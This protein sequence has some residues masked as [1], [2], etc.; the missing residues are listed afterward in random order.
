M[1]NKKRPDCGDAQVPAHD[2]T[3][4]LQT[5]ATQLL[6]IIGTPAAYSIHDDGG[7]IQTDAVDRLAMASIIRDLASSYAAT[8]KKRIAGTMQV[9]DT[10]TSQLGA[11]LN[12]SERKGRKILAVSE[13]R[14]QYD[15]GEGEVYDLITRYGYVHTA[16]ERLALGLESP[17]NVHLDRYNVRLRGGGDG[18]A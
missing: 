6:R 4:D 13:M 7:N 9:G 12:V 5:I 3:D 8:L 18:R 15:K 16:E 10:I 1:Q 17:V 11:T 2:T 14:T